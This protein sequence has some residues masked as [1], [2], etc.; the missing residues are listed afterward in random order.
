MTSTLIGKILVLVVTSFALLFLG[1][2]TVVFSM[3][4][5]WQARKDAVSKKVQELQ[6]KNTEL[7][8]QLAGAKNDLA[9]VQESQVAALKKQE[10]IVASLEA[11]I[12]QTTDE[13]EASRVALKDAQQGAR[14]AL[15]ASTESKKKIDE[16]RDEKLAVDKQANDFKVRK[17]ELNDEIRDLKRMLETATNNA[18]DLRSRVTRSSTSSGR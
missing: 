8:A 17:A 14:T 3:A 1:I 18:K 6:G 12:R 7:T 13:I 10:D 2:S 11:K 9:K 16:V 5:D 15:E 4:P